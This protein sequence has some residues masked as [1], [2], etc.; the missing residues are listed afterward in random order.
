MGETPRIL[1]L[2]SKKKK[3][4]EIEKER[5]YFRGLGKGSTTGKVLD[6]YQV[7]KIMCS[8]GRKL[9]SHRWQKIAESWENRHLIGKLCGPVIRAVVLFPPLHQ[10]PD[11]MEDSRNRAETWSGSLKGRLELK[12]KLGFGALWHISSSFVFID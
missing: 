5:N 7:S 2:T 11:T 12:T 1:S 8:L 4:K 9:G 10:Y 3:K 6:R